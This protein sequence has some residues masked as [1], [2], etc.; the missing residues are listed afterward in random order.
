[1]KNLLILLIFVSLP[2]FSQIYNVDNDGTYKKQNWLDNKIG[3]TYS[4]MTG[5]GLSYQR[6]FTETIGLKS[7][8]FAY[9]SVNDDPN[10]ENTFDDIYISI[11]SELQFN[12]KKYE[13]TRLY[14]LAG[15]FYRYLV[16]DD[17]MYF[18][19]QNYGQD[20][21]KD[22]NVGLG[23]GLEFMMDYNFSISLDGGFHFNYG[24][25]D[26][27]TM[28]NG[29]YVPVKTNPMEF[30]FAFGLSLFYNF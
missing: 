7:Q 4:M 28:Q 9:G 29:I 16:E 25:L 24:I 12:L 26:S 13:S 20:K 2:V 14:L 18:G 8:F 19:N 10:T 17:Y 15:G 21:R 22:I 27:Y 23:F 6:Q 30:G 3:F 11:G 5:Y 1:M